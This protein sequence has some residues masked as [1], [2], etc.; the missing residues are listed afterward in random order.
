[1]NFKRRWCSKAGERNS[2][3]WRPSSRPVEIFRG[4]HVPTCVLPCRSDKLPI[5]RGLARRFTVHEDGDCLPKDGW[6]DTWILT[7]S[8]NF[9]RSK[10]PTTLSR[11]L[12][13]ETR[14]TRS[15]NDILNEL[16][17]LQQRGD[18]SNGC[19]INADV[20]QL[21]KCSLRMFNC[22]YFKRHEWRKI[23]YW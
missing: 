16:Y 2:S 18:C 4:N 7:K 14:D 3:T 10:F 5:P 19:L 15:L 9:I 6:N 23:F 17:T 8:L 1:M 20:L 21:E 13:Y 12:R 22:K 11:S